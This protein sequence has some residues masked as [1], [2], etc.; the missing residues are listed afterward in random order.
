MTSTIVQYTPH[1]AKASGVRTDSR[2]TALTWA[3]QT[4]ARRKS[5]TRI[6]VHTHQHNQTQSASPIE[7]TLR[8]LSGGGHL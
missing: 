2:D 8:W 5:R 3:R 4:V 1:T 7:E 6:P